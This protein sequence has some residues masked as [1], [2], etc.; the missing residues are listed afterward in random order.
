MTFLKMDWMGPQNFYGGSVK[1]C[2]TTPFKVG[3]ETRDMISSL[4]NFFGSN[5]ITN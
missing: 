4:M 1:L 3:E 5:E 2:R